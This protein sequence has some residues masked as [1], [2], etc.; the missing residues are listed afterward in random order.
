VKK[1][2]IIVNPAAGSKRKRNIEQEIKT[3]SGLKRL[4][5]TVVFW[6]TDEQLAR[7]FQEIRQENKALIIAA[8]GDGTVNHILQLMDTGHQILAILPW[9]SGNGLARHL[10]IYQ[11]YR[12][13]RFL[14]EKDRKTDCDKAE[15]AGKPFINVAGI[16]F[17]AHISL[18]FNRYPKRRGLLNYVLHTLGAFFSYQEKSYHLMVDGE[19]L[20]YSAF[21]IA[22]ANGTQWG[23]NVHI[24]QDAL[25]DDG[26]LNLVIMSKPKLWQI[27]GLLWQMTRKSPTTRNHRLMKRQRVKHVRVLGSKTV[28]AHADGEAL[29][30][31]LPFEVSIAGSCRLCI[32]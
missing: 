29:C 23:N 17:D 24:A 26:Y 19:E 9:G 7:V 8:G 10:G 5:P 28:A 20:H 15:I 32:G 3:N 14:I 25:L 1:C 6:K 12:E 22:F 27:P 2:F 31:Q 16:G 13:G 21:L 30:L 11:K 4:K 18:L